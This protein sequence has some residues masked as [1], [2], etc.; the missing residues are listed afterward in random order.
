MNRSENEQY[1]KILSIFHYVVGGIAALFACFPIIH[2]VVGLTMLLSSFI[3]ALLPSPEG[4][5]VFPVLPFSLVGLF[6]TLFAGGAILLGW[7]FAV[8][9]I[10]AG[11]SLAMRKRYMFC[12]VMAGIACMFTPFGTVLGVFTIIVLMQPAVKEMFEANELSGT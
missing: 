1:L 5:S 8:C 7:A 11:R 2:F 6:F 9:L 3:P 4:S 12:L 10:I